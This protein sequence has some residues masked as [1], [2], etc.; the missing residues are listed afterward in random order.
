MSLADLDHW[1]VDYIYNQVV[2]S[3]QGI[4]WHKLFDRLN[5]I[6]FW[7]SHFLDDNRVADAAWAKKR[8]FEETFEGTELE[9]PTECSVLEMIFALACRME[10]AVMYNRQLGDRSGLWFWG[11]IVNLGLG[12]MT[13]EHYDDNFVVERVNAFLARSYD[14]NGQGGLF[15][16]KNKKYDMREY[17]IWRQA[18]LYML[19]F[20]EENGQ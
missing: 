15:S 18:N 12:H 10:S 19:E 3:D 8:A 17:D 1:Y 16:V 13:D 4:S 6:P 7:P 9:L 14:K 11:M 2:Q 5:A 20:I